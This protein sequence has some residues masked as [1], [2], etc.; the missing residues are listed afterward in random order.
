M[1]PGITIGIIGLIV[2]LIGL[3]LTYV[4]YRKN[5]RIKIPL[6]TVEN[7]GP[8]GVI[9]EDLSELSFNYKGEEVK[10]FTV[11]RIAIWNAGKDTIH[12]T[13]V[14]E[15]DPIQIVAEVGYKFLDAN[16]RQVINSSNNFKIKFCPKE[17]L[18]D[19]DYMGYKEGCCVEVYHNG[20][21][22]WA[23][24][25]SGSIKG[26]GKI[27]HSQYIPY[28]K[29]KKKAYLVSILTFFIGSLISLLMFSLSDTE[30][31]RKIIGINAIVAGFVYAITPMVI[32][33]L[34][35]QRNRTSIELGVI[36]DDQQLRA[37]DFP[38][39]G[40]IRERDKDADPIRQTGASKK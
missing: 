39:T 3:S 23:L 8:T 28:P 26:I 40:R 20:K 10:F 32:N 2:G 24:Q 29:R 13:D 9:P 11:S 15:S 19:F 7:R 12:S 36:D 30:V 34:Y 18:I 4:F 22:S 6:F 35:F 21:T 27:K 5:L 16:I 38:P 17:I 37:L 31:L 25:V 14:V 33:T 1:D